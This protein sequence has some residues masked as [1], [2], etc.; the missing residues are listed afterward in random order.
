MVATG[1]CARRSWAL[2]IAAALSGALSLAGCSGGQPGQAAS[3]GSSAAAANPNLDLGTPLG[4]KPVPDIRLTNQFGQPMSL[5]QFRGKVMLI[6]FVDSECT[7]VCPLTTLAML[8]AK[9]MLG[10]AGDRVQLLGIDANPDAITTSD[11]LG[12]SRAHSMVNRWDFLTGTLPQ[13]KAAWKAFDI[14]AK[15]DSG[16]VDHT[17]ALYVVDA[18]GR[19]QV[20]YLTAMAYSSISQSAQVVAQ[21]V[22][23]LL[24]GHPVLAHSQSLAYITGQTPAQTARLPAAFPAGGPVT[25]GPGQ[26]RLVVFYATWLSEIT[27]L[28]DELTSL[29][30]YVQAARARHLPALTAVD[31]AV[32]EPTSTAAR[33]YL[34][35]LKQ[36]LVLPGRPRHHRPRRGRLRRPGSALVR[37]HVSGRQD[38]LVTRRLAVPRRPRSRRRQARLAGAAA[39]PQ[40]RSRHRFRDAGVDRNELIRA[41]QVE[42]PCHR[43]LR[44]GERELAAAV[45]HHHPDVQ[46]D[47]HAGGVHELQP[48]QIHDE[49]RDPPG[50]FRLQGAAQLVVRV[51][52]GLTSER[53]HGVGVS[54]RDGH[55]KLIHA[56]LV[57]LRPPKRN[58][59]P[60]LRLAGLRP[61]TDS[62]RGRRRCGL[63]V[64][65]A[66]YSA[67]S[68]T[69]VTNR[70]QPAAREDKRRAVAAVLAVTD[71]DRAGGQFADLDALA[72]STPGTFPPADTGRID[73]VHLRTFRRKQ[74]HDCGARS[75]LRISATMSV[76]RFS[77]VAEIDSHER[78]CLTSPGGQCA[79][80]SYRTSRS[81]LPGE[82]Q[83]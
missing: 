5:R 45:V 62:V 79:G 32:T 82:A 56:P 51:H 65:S 13:L 78:S 16:Q 28:G 21:E 40:R 80:P 64:R 61:R 48:G 20:V 43:V 83:F 38:R 53:D 7:T 10:A 6:G 18:Q 33:G 14:Y 30:S 22:A 60:W 52:V 26:P 37:A 36:P 34:Q 41:D 68:L 15:I 4:G 11:V 42:D 23:S 50:D 8:E 72:M 39:S 44:L 76:Q 27:N 73:R 35:G 75:M 31:E 1:R 3:P 74:E 29:N 17:P 70:R 63:C 12:Y 9:Q 46:Q 71:R 54:A 2:L 55:P 59:K 25:L 81:A 69:V 67:P 47:L 66:A 57:P 19:E 58:L 49:E 24:P 77:H